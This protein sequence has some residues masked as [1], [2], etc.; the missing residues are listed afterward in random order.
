MLLA[1]LLVVLMT[2]G[3]GA[4]LDAMGGVTVDDQP[5]VVKVTQGETGADGEVFVVS[6][7]SVGDGE[8]EEEKVSVQ[9][10]VLG[11][12]ADGGLKDLRM[13]TAPG[14]FVWHSADDSDG[15]VLI[16]A[17]SAGDED[18]DGPHVLKRY[19][20][21]AVTVTFEKDQRVTGTLLSFDAGTLVV[22]PD[23]EGPRNITRSEIRD[24]RFAKLPAGLRTR[25]TL[26]WRL[27]SQKA[28][29]QRN[30]EVA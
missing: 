16:R 15:K 21:K 18:D 23:G 13:A 4:A 17:F 24:I 22:Q 14:G 25:P 10:I 11:A 29:R 8:G 20:D 27:K 30:F 9:C 2:C 19:I 1:Q 5:I 28:A 12:G 3:F 26:M 7:G 6:Q